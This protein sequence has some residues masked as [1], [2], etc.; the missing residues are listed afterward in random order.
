ML[1]EGTPAPSPG[2]YV[3]IIGPEAFIAAQ[4]IWCRDGRFAVRTRERL[5]VSATATELRSLRLTADELAAAPGARRRNSRA[6]LATATDPNS[7]AERSRIAGRR[8]EHVAIGTAAAIA[9]ALVAAAVY[10]TLAQPLAA[11]AAGSSLRK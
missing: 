7:Q 1:L 9:A 5:N 3:E 10:H 11:V 8:V 2:T 4:V 6:D